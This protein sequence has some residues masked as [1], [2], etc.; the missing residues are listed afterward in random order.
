VRR[1]CSTS[2]GA[3]VTP[4][5]SRRR[6]SARRSKYP[7]RATSYSSPCRRPRRA[8]MSRHRRPRP[9]RRPRGSTGAGG[10]RRAGGEPRAEG[11]PRVGGEARAG[12]EPRRLRAPR[13]D[14]P[15]GGTAASSADAARK[16]F[17]LKF[18]TPS[19]PPSQ[20]CA[21]PP[22]NYAQHAPSF[23]ASTRAAACRARGRPARRPLGGRAVGRSASRGLR[24][25]RLEASTSTRWRLAIEPRAAAGR[26][27]AA[28]LP[29]CRVRAAGP[30][31][32]PAGCQTA[33]LRSSRR[34]SAEVGRIRA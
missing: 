34:A 16:G 1:R 32:A 29:L 24:E 25:T 3:T 6:A 2:S 14:R 12:R 21:S 23:P 10:E 30:F 7:L 27:R 13:R 4:T 28:G 11:E 31:R 26:Q 22:H 5:S 9:Q 17:P 19:A 15:K 18:V 8:Q 33:E 20:Q